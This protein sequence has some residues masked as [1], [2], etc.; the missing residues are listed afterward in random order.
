LE[1]PVLL[2]AGVVK[3]FNSKPD[4]MFGFLITG[5]TDVHFHIE[6]YGDVDADENGR[7]TLVEPELPPERI[8]QHY[9]DVMFMRDD[10]R[11]RGS[12]TFGWC[13]ADDYKRA[14]SRWVMALL[15]DGEV[16]E[17]LFEGIGLDLM[18]SNYGA[19][20]DRYWDDWTFRRESFAHVL[21]Q[22]AARGL[23]VL[24]GCPR[25]QYDEVDIQVCDQI[26]NIFQIEPG[27]ARREVIIGLMQMTRED[28]VIKRRER[29]NV[30]S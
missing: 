4:K 26:V 8:P 30:S 15:A 10:T 23:E 14:K 19:F 11:L 9:D 6:Q 27:F 3:F 17:N 7:M 25:E 24:L 16:P 1:Q 29:Q 20:R 5:R 18:L 2:E 13:Y 22:D 21:A 12:S 28:P